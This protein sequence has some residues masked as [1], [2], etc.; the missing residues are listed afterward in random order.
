MTSE[1]NLLDLGESS[2]RPTPPRVDHTHSVADPFSDLI[3]DNW[4][5]SPVTQPSSVVDNW[6]TC[7]SPQA[8]LGVDNW[9]TSPPT[10]ASAGVDVWTTSPPTQTSSG[11]SNWA[12][13]PLTQ[14]LSGVHAADLL[15]LLTATSS[16]SIHRNVSAP[17]FQP[18]S[19]NFDPFAEF[20]SQSASSPSSA[21]A[22]ATNSGSTTPMPFRPNY[23]RTAFESISPSTTAKPK[24]T[25]DAFGELL[26]SQGFTASTKSATS[27]TLCDL[28]RADNIKDMDPVAIKI[29]DW[30]DGKE[31]NIRALL[32][33]LNDVLWEG[34]EKWQQPRMADLLSAVQV[35]K[36]YYK[37]CLVVHPDKQVGAPMRSWRERSSPS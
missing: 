33:S 6:A 11:A 5:T 1:F 8:S 36:S 16:F 2:A 14:T 21:Q 7:P 27:R 22:S 34:A 17:A 26:S 12:T 19:A 20:L 28:R 37:A 10:Q 23:S 18:S 13:S 35:K 9:T 29:R 32:G 4:T 3:S 30:T 15:D 31:R 25:G 24:V